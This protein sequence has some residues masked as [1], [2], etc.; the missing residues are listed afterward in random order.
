MLLISL[1]CSA[2][3]TTAYTEPMRTVLLL[4]VSF[5]VGCGNPDLSDASMM[6]SV[7]CSAGA[8]D[9]TGAIA[10]PGPQ[11][12]TAG[13]TATVNGKEMSTRQGRSTYRQFNYSLGSSLREDSLGFSTWSLVP[14]LDQEA[15]LDVVVTDGVSRVSARFANPCF[16]PQLRFETASGSSELPTGRPQDVLVVAAEEGTTWERES[17]TQ[18]E[19]ETSS[20]IPFLVGSHE[21]LLEPKGHRLLFTVPWFRD[22]GR[23][24]LT[25]STPGSARLVPIKECSGLARCRVSS[26]TPTVL[27]WRFDVP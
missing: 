1:A 27:R 13:F 20:L 17:W 22:L 24:E 4:T 26:A 16:G 12:T 8:P 19:G 10:S 5:L 14:G 18:T 3:T 9:L 11:Q 7:Q 23:Q 25:L 2:G 21:V 6:I 15:E